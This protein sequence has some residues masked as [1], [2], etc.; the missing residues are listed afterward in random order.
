MSDSTVSFLSDLLRP[1]ATDGLIQ[2][3]PGIAAENLSL[4]TQVSLH[5]VDCAKAVMAVK[6]F[7]ALHALMEHYIT[8]LG[9]TDYAILKLASGCRNGVTDILTTLPDQYIQQYPVTWRINADPFMEYARQNTAPALYSDIHQS[10]NALPFKVAGLSQVDTV[11]ALYGGFDIED[12]LLVPMKVVGCKN[13]TLM[14]V[15]KRGASIAAMRMLAET[16]IPQLQLVAS[17]VAA[18]LGE[19]FL[20]VP[21]RSRGVPKPLVNPKPLNVL[22]TLANHDYTIGQVADFLHISVVTTN[23]HL[24]SVRKGLGVKTNYAA[25]KR[26][27]REGLI[28]YH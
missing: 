15:M 28:E 17:V 21:F 14:I 2:K 19:R 16:Q 3:P 4:T 13:T 5:A 1:L 18:T 8:D 10:L 11:Q 23:K 22:M 26:A 9:F 25:I 20:G 12:V 24:E 6:S 27:L 7:E